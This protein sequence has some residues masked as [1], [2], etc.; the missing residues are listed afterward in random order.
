MRFIGMIGLLC[1]AIL[2]IVTG[3]LRYHRPAES[4]LY[5]IGF[6]SERDGPPNRYITVSDGDYLRR[7]THFNDP[8]N[9]Y[10]AD[11]TARP[12]ESALRTISIADGQVANVRWL[13]SGE[14][15]SFAV[16]GGEPI[17]ALYKVNGDGSG[18]E[19]ILDEIPT[20]YAWASDGTRLA[21]VTLTVGGSTPPVY[22]IYVKNI[23]TGEIHRIANAGTANTTVAWSPDDAALLFWGQSGIYGR[24]EIYLVR[25]DGTGLRNISHHPARDDDPR[26]GP[27]IDA[28][29][30]S[31]RWLAL[32]GLMAVIGSII[33]VGGYL[34]WGK[35]KTTPLH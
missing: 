2:L 33:G 31:V 3:W 30:H 9:P 29:W 6:V 13:P 7:G 18:L 24:A 22:Q 8:D 35:E 26:W 5:W 32:G 20:A 12:S 17:Q 16:Y 15:L 28:P 27:A 14:A 11:A 25:A 19:R 21:Y 10:P 1:G 23:V 34:R 4:H